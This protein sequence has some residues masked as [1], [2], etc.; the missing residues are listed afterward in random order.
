LSLSYALSQDFDSKFQIALTTENLQQAYELLSKQQQQSPSLALA[1]VQKWKKLGDLALNKWN[2]KMAQ[3]S[4]WL[5]NDYSSLLL[6]LSSTNNKAQLIKLAE[7]CEEKGRYNISWQAWWLVGDVNKCLDLLIKSGRYPEAILFGRNYGVDHERL[8]NY[9]KEFKDVLK[10]K[11]K[12]KI[13]ERLIDD[14]EDLSINNGVASDGDV[15]ATAATAAPLINLEEESQ[16]KQ[17]DDVGERETEAKEVHEVELEKE[18]DDA[19]GGV[20]V[21]ETKD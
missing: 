8:S 13:S 1:N 15:A 3:E 4:F 9:I 10:L 12:D 2:L 16:E 7:K 6:L 20:E 14:F 11:K 5:A 18:N 19:N 21:T 17:E